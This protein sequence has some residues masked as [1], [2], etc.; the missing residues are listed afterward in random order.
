M[1]TAQTLATT[2]LLCALPTSIDALAKVDTRNLDAVED[3]PSRGLMHVSVDFKDE[4][5]HKHKDECIAAINEKLAMYPELF[6]HRPAFDFEVNKIREKTDEGYN[7]VSLR[8]NA[9]ET[10]VGG[11]LGDGMIWYPYEWC[12]AAEDCYTIGPWDCD[13]GIP[14]KAEECCKMIQDS[15][16]TADLNGNY[17]ECY[18]EYPVGSPSNPVNPGRVKLHI[19]A[20]GYVVHIPKNE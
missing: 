7:Y 1:K 15:V 16:P 4:C 2:A 20:A 17:L 18:N 12:L 14:L 13:V 9:D 5:L 11:L 19:D 10:T 6:D 8:M 3:D